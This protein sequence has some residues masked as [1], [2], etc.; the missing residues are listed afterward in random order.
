MENKKIEPKKEKIHVFNGED[1]SLAS[2]RLGGGSF[3]VFCSGLE[4][5]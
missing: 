3:P 2:W 1:A 5:N 4:G